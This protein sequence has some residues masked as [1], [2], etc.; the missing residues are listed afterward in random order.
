MRDIKFRAK[1][2]SSKIDKYKIGDWIYYS[3][4]DVFENNFGHNLIEVIPESVGQ[5][6]GKHDIKGARI[7]GGDKI[8]WIE[9]PNTP[10]AVHKEMAEKLGEIKWDESRAEFGAKFSGFSGLYTML[11]AEDS[12]EIIGNTTDN[13]NL[14]EG[15]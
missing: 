7:Y 10:V 12:W 11:Y 13:P 3:T 5:Y 9:H 1:I 15:E 2:K 14:L 4:K 8:K 6:T